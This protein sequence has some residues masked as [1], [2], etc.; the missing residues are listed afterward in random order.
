MPSPSLGFQVCLGCE[1]WGC[2]SCVDSSEQDLQKTNPIHI[3]QWTD[4]V[5]L[6][7]VQLCENELRI[8]SALWP[9]LSAEINDAAVCVSASH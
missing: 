6:L 9:F 7:L 1:V 8:I 3:F 2:S 5:S 4:K